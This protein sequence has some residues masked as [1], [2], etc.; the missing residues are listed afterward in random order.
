MGSAWWLSSQEHRKERQQKVNVIEGKPDRHSFSHKIKVNADSDVM[1]MFVY[2][3]EK[4]WWEW[5]FTSTVF[6]PRTYNP[7][8]P[9]RKI[10]NFSWRTFYQT[11]ANLFSEMSVPRKT[12]AEE[13]VQLT[14]DYT[15]RAV[16]SNEG[17]R[18]G[19]RM[20]KRIHKENYSATGKICQLT[21][22]LVILYQNYIF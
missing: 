21:L 15:D 12:K 16:Q 6:F 3:L 5:H 7:N 13:L 9:M 14:R 11:T 10:S 4:I 2:Y 18:S 22:Y 1:L 20:K 8:L 17:H 19:S